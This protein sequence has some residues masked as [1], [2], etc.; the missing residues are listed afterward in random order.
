MNKR[1]SGKKIAETIKEDL[2]K[3]ISVLDREIVF[4]I[5]YIGTDSVIDNFISYKK[6]FGLDLGVDVLVHHF[7]EDIDQS[8]LILEM[9]SIEEQSDAM[10]VQLPLPDHLDVQSILDIVPVQKDVDVLSSESKKQFIENIN[11]MFPPVTGAVIEVFK[12]QEYDLLDK[13]IVLVGYGSLVGKPFSDWLLGQKIQHNIIT[14]ETDE[15]IKSELFKKA[16]IIVSGV[17][18]P[19]LI[20]PEMVSEDIVLIDAGTSESGK[21]VIG[22][23][24]PKCYKKSLFYTPVPGGIGPLTIAVLYQNILKS[25]QK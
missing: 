21:K 8:D 14:K 11:P 4:S 18:S 7:P 24:D 13:K 20:Q 6:K 5:I 22:D 12:D 25:I 23:I 15:N 2:K 19:H 17:G 3:E 10:I 1:V 9:K 16:D